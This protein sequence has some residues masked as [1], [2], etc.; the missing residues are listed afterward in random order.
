MFTYPQIWHE[1]LVKGLLQEMGANLLHG[2]LKK[3][4]QKEETELF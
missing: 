3:K 1:L 2:T 4:N